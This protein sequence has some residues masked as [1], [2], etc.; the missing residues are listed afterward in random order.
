M[1]NRDLP[2][3]RQCPW[4]L[5]HI[6]SWE[7]KTNVTIEFPDLENMSIP[8]ISVLSDQKMGNQ[9]LPLG[10]QCP[11]SLNHIRSW[12]TKTNITIGFPDLK[13]PKN[14]KDHLFI[15]FNNKDKE[16]FVKFTKNVMT[17]CHDVIILTSCHDIWKESVWYIMQDILVEELEKFKIFSSNPSW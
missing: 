5:N 10:R 12:K 7:T 15:T 2:L 6:R 11:W 17:P 3:G 1:G 8:K 13:K 16:L 14:K 4:S 9:G